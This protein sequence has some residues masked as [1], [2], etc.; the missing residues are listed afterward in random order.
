[1]IRSLSSAAALSVKVKA[2]IFRGGQALALAGLED[3]GDPLG[4]HLGLA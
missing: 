3:G 2:T 1:M 4:D